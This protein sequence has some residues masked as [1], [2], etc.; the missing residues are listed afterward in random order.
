VDA[1]SLR[2]SANA[3]RLRDD[4][5]PFRISILM[6]A[7]PLTPRRTRL[8][9]ADAMLLVGSLSALLERVPARSVRLTV[10]NL[11]QQKELYRSADFTADAM[12]Q[13]WQSLN[14]LELNLVDY[15]TLQNRTGHLDLL[16]DLINQETRAEQ[17][18]DAVLILGPVARFVDQL[19]HSDV[20]RPAGS[21]P[22]FFF[23]QY[24]PWTRQ[25]SGLTDTL[26]HTVNSLKGKVFTIRTPG[27][28]A[29]AIEQ[30]EKRAT[31]N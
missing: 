9:A 12:Q 29:K 10:F 5:P 26:T 30:L 14:S 16:A 13:V 11:E 18:S 8:R 2:G 19:S 15:H 20:D 31:G 23:F 6:H 28:F 1:Y 27:E 3:S 17:P 22:R 24:R 4:A 21:V 7:A 25:E